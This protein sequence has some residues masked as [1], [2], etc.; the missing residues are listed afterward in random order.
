MADELGLVHVE[1]DSKHGRMGSSA[2]R[3]TRQDWIAAYQAA[4]RDVEA[5]LDAGESIVFDA[6]SYRRLQ[7]NR[8]RRIA[9]ARGV[10]ATVVLLDI[11]PQV[12]RA[13]LEVN[14]RTRERVNV[15]SGDF[16]EVVAGM[17]PPEPGEETIR[18]RSDE[19]IDIWI[20]RVARPLLM[21]SHGVEESPR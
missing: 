7:R 19:P 9:E 1:V 3:L 12:A 13:R 6:V 21:D 14:R 16:A 5:A 17:Q 10:L 20:E 2:P 8:V 11:S 4:Y 15:P 18:Y